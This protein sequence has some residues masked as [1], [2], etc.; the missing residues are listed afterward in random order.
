MKPKNNE[1]VCQSV[2]RVILLTSEELLRAPISAALPLITVACHAFKSS[3]EGF[4]FETQGQLKPKRTCGHTLTKGCGSHTHRIENNRLSILIRVLPLMLC[5]FRE[6]GSGGGTIP[7]TII[8]SRLVNVP[9]FINKPPGI[10]ARSSIS[11]G[12]VAIIGEAPSAIV[13][14]ADCVVTTTFVIFLDH[15]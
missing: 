4:Q 10:F 5:E 6:A 11:S 15:Q 2:G 7:A 8:P 12:D 9:K 1:Q 3:R 13:A 14:F